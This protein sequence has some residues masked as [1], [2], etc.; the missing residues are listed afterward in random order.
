[1]AAT[2]GAHRRFDSGLGQRVE[3]APEHQQ[4]SVFVLEQEFQVVGEFIAR[5]VTLVENSP[6]ALGAPAAA[7]VLVGYTARPSHGRGD[8]QLIHECGSAGQTIHRSLETGALD[9]ARVM[10]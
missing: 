2:R 9:A 10:Q 5:P 3:D 8:R 1:M 6:G 7:H 4:V